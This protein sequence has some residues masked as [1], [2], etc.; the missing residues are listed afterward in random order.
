MTT[1][2]IVLGVLGG[3][4]SGKSAVAEILSALGAVVIDADALAHEALEDLEIRAAL[5]A[6]FGAQIVGEDG[7]LNRQ[8]IA[9]E[10]FGADRKS[11]LEWLNGLIHPQVRSEI[12]ARLTKARHEG[13]N[14][15]VLD[16]PLLLS[17]PLRKHCDYLVFVDTDQARREKH[18]A[19]RGWSAQE[20]AERESCQ[21]DLDT[22]R[23]AADFVIVNDGDIS[24][25][26]SRIKTLITELDREA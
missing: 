26:E 11:E 1:T 10:V 12:E 2:T 16:V 25:L 17:S 8:V 5:I 6:R 13:R 24:V 3:I 7:A 14:F 18:V 23:H 22:K 15:V 20:L 4:G 19:L 21:N 9:K